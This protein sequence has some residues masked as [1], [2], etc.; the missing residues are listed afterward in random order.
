MGS[1]V[2]ITTLLGAADELAWTGVL[3]RP[4]AAALET[5]GGW[6]LG[7]DWGWMLGAATVRG[8]GC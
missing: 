8:T 7:M 6:M 5:A 1:L 4:I 2:F 3:A